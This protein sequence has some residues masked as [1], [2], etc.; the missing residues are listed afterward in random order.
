MVCEVGQPVKMMFIV[1]DVWAGKIL[2]IWKILKKILK[3]SADLI[4]DDEQFV[5]SRISATHQTSIDKTQTKKNVIKHRPE[6][7]R[8]M[9]G[10]KTE[11]I[12][13]HAYRYFS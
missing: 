2:K 5:I 8:L 7:T 11:I 9:F 1:S 6:V 3:T 13:C 4:L 10:Q 12:L